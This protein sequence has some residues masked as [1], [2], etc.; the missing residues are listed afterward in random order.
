MPVRK[1]HWHPSMW[2]STLTVRVH[3]EVPGQLL[4]ALVL[5]WAWLHY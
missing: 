4:F 5:A 3:I 2:T 1:S